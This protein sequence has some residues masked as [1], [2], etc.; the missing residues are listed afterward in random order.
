MKTKKRWIFC[1]LVF[2]ASILTLPLWAETKQV[3]TSNIIEYDGKNHNLTDTIVS[4]RWREN[5]DWKEGIPQ[6]KNSGKYEFFIK[7]ETRSCY[8]KNCLYL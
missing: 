3:T 7:G 6:G 1:F 8:K 4:Y 5:E 2:F